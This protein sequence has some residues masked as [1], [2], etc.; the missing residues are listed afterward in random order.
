[1]KKPVRHCATR[2]TSTY[3]MLVSLRSLKDF[4]DENSEIFALVS[5]EFWREVEDVVKCLQPANEAT[6]I[7]KKQQLTMGDFYITW[8]NCKNSIESINH[9]FAVALHTS[10]TH[11]ELK[12]LENDVVLEA[13]YIDSRL[14]VLLSLEQCQK[15]RMLLKE[16]YL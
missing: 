12:L 3:N 13:L 8:L 16:V 1:M 4:C 11:R 15:A 9:S 14:S 2:W 6:L 10:F 5:N 7:L